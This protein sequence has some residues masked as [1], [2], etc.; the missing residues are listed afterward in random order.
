MEGKFDLSLNFSEN[1][2]AANAIK[3]CIRPQDM[4]GKSAALILR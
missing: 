1:K 4:T 2:Y 3:H